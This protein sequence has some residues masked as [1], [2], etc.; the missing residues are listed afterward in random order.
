[1]RDNFD[2]TLTYLKKIKINRQAKS[3]I[4]NFFL[5]AQVKSIF[6]GADWVM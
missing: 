6:F 4:D 5:I 2:W 1:M 3:E